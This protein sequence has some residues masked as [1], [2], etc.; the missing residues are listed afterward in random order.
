M[1]FYQ[2]NPIGAKVSEMKR[3]EQ[4]NFMVEFAVG[5]L[6]FF[7]LL[8]GVIEISR[9]LFTVNTLAEAT[10]RGARYAAVCNN[11]DRVKRVTVFLDP[12]AGNA[13][14]IISGLNVSHVQVSD[15]VVAGTVRVSINTGVGGFQSNLLIPNLNRAM[16]LPTFATTM[17]VE[18]QSVCP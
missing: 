10:R 9:W 17:P 5:G 8:F 7:T 16:A 1:D 11:P 4:G 2:P 13:S 6:A 3:S 18:D 12:A 15:G 14:P